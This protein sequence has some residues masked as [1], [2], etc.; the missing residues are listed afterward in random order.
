MPIAATVLVK[1]TS[2]RSDYRNQKAQA[3]MEAKQKKSE[4]GTGI[5]V[6]I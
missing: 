3:K 1:G 6:Q 4:W 5:Y 2:N